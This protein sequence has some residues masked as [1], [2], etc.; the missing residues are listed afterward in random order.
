MMSIVPVFRMLTEDCQ[1]ENKEMRDANEMTRKYLDNILIEER[2]ID[3]K[4]SDITFDI[5]GKSFSTPITTPAFSHL[6]VYSEG[7]ENGLIEYSRAMSEMGAMNWVG[8]GDNDAIGPVMDACDG[9]VRIIKPYADRDKIFKQIDFAKEHGALAVGI[10]TDHIFGMDGELDVVIGE[11]MDLQ[12]SEYIRE[13]VEY[14]KIPFIIKGVLSVKDAL[15]AAECGVKGIVVSHHHG[16]M[17][18]AIPPLMV[19]PDIRKSL[20]DYP[21]MKIF[22]DCHIDSGADAYK[23]I[24]LGADAVSVGRVILPSL[25]KNGVKGVVDFISAMNAELKTIMN[26]TGAGTLKEIDSSILWDGSRINI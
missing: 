21:D 18:Y 23:A 14:A 20:K 7:R 9:T 22:V 10:D 19:L 5:W 1:R 8:M 13:Y 4:V 26:F 25:E 11:K 2:L 16:R 17:P 6:P 24:A 12:S 15:K 3:A